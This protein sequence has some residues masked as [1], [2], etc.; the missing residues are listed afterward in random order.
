MF[1]SVAFSTSLNSLTIRFFVTFSL[2]RFF[3]SIKSNLLQTDEK[4]GN[5]RN[6]YIKERTKRLGTDIKRLR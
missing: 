1:L 2:K 6:L 4:M 3:I 5:R